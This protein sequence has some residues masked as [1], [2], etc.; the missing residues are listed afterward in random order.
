MG[1]PSAKVKASPSVPRRELAGPLPRMGDLTAA[2]GDDGKNDVAAEESP[3]DPKKGKKSK[4][5]LKMP[6]TLKR[7]KFSEV[8]RAC[9][10]VVAVMD[11][12]TW[13][14]GAAAR[15][16][17]NRS[18]STTELSRCGLSFMLLEVQNVWFSAVYYS[19]L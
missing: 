2:I 16:T 15:C 13:R 1:T 8:S 6:S 11:F 7:G 14:S 17:A 3:T 9:S 5:G 19:K 10:F 12:A 18:L 4:F